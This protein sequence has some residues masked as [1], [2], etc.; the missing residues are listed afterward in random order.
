MRHALGWSEDIIALNE[1]MLEEETNRETP[2]QNINMGAATGVGMGLDADGPI[3]GEGL[4][5]NNEGP[6]GYEGSIGLG[7][8]GGGA[9]VGNGSDI[10]GNMEALNIVYKN[11]NLFEDD[12]D[13]PS[14]RI[15]FDVNNNTPDDGSFADDPIAGKPITTLAIIQKLRHAEF[16]KRVNWQ[17]RLNMLNRIY[18]P[19]DDQSGGMGAF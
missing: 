13:L 10:G 19:D 4:V 16:S 17:K 11:K 15:E 2:D 5:A 6:Q 12:I 18:S 9:D 8:E 1:K 3:S 7:A 14:E